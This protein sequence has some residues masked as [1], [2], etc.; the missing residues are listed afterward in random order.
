MD[1]QPSTD[2][3]AS[4]LGQALTRRK[5]FRGV[6]AA[7][8]GAAG[9]ATLE[10]FGSRASAAGGTTVEPGGVAPAVVQLT[11]AATIAVNASLGNDF[12]V[13]VGGN[14]T[15]GNPSSPTDGQQ[16]IFQITQG[17]GGPF[18]ISW[19]SSYEFSA[20]LPQPTL[21]TTAG[22]TDLL[23][24]IYYAATDTWLLAAFLNGFS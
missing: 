24:F 7:A 6:G 18:T 1:G 3:P 13:T 5:I 16:I 10:A 19:G 2:R 11:D 22:L 14:R 17:T 21:S 23:G 12:R 4:G 8:I 20:G 15:M 9:G